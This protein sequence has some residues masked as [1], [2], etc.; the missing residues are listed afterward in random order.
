VAA[1]RQG[2]RWLH[3]SP[4]ED[5]VKEWFNTVNLHSGM[6]HGPYMG[7]I[8]L[9]GATEKVKATR[10]KSGGDQATYVIEQEQVVF[11]PYV[12]VD[13]R[14][15][16]FWDYVRALNGGELKGDYVGLIEPVPQRR[17]TDRAS[18]YYNEHLPEGFGIYPVRNSNDTVNR[19]LVCTS[20]VAIYERADYGRVIAGEKA[21]A[22]LVGSGSKQVPMARQWGDDYA[23]MKAETGAIGR[24]L[25]VAGILVVGTGVATAEDMQ[26]A[27]AGPVGAAGASAEGATL[28]AADDGAA[29][30]DG[31]GESAALP[32]TAEETEEA[33]LARALELRAEMQRDFP[34]VWTA[35]VAWWNERGYGR[36]ED[37]PGP[38][39]K[40]VVIKLERDLDAARGG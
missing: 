12:K 7:G 9:I 34:D 22:L 29:V 35:Y 16:Y 38:A 8:V 11:V 20:R 19:Y 18:P 33:L 13:T 30:P 23:V 40:G 36:P 25:G 6:D 24:A 14:I 39:L 5:E 21:P 15:A 1:V 10:R 2:S 37:L 31:P 32:A 17:I 3:E 4:S 28:G 26:E 27:Q